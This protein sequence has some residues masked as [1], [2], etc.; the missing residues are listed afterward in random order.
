MSFFQFL[1]SIGFPKIPLKFYV[2]ICNA[3]M[4]FA[5]EITPVIINSAIQRSQG[6]NPPPSLYGFSFKLHQEFKPVGPVDQA[7]I[8]NRGLAGI[9]I[10]AVLGGNSRT[11]GPFIVLYL[12]FSIFRQAEDRVFDGPVCQLVPCL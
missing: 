3:P 1:L 7:S 12:F 10:L 11:N 8:H 5:T 4:Y 9:K 2:P 6:Y